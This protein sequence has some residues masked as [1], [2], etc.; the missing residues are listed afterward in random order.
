M[1]ARLNWGIGVEMESHFFLT[2]RV[3]GERQ[4]LAQIVGLFGKDKDNLLVDMKN[5]HKSAQLRKRFGFTKAESDL[6]LSSA[7]ADLEMSA[8]K[9]AGLKPP[10]AKMLELINVDYRNRTVA[11]IAAEMRRNTRRI[12]SVLTKALHDDKTRR[13]MN[14]V[15][16]KTKRIARYPFGAAV[17][18]DLLKQ[19]VVKDYTGSF[20]FTITLPYRADISNSQFIVMH[21]RF[22]NHL[23]WLEPLLVGCLF[24][25]DP[26]CVSEPMY[27]NAAYRTVRYGWGNFAGTDVRRLNKGVGRKANVE[28]LWRRNLNVRNMSNLMT[29]KCMTRQETAPASV[30]DELCGKYGQASSDLRTFGI[31]DRTRVSGPPMTLGNGFEFRIFD[32]FDIGH[33]QDVMTMIMYVAENSR[34]CRYDNEQVYRDLDWISALQDVIHD[35]WHATVRQA[36]VDKV[37]R[38]LELPRVSCV[39]K[40]VHQVTVDVFAALFAKNKGGAWLKLMLGP[41]DARRRFSVPDVNRAAWLHYYKC[42][43]NSA[44]RRA[45]NVALNRIPRGARFRADRAGARLKT[46]H[47]KKQMALVL[48]AEKKEYI[49]KLPGGAYVRLKKLPIPLAKIALTC[50]DKTS[51]CAVK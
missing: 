45:I 28:P 51:N 21:E 7:I 13:A 6:F 36:Y 39:R 34:E 5:P 46:P 22:G 2:D 37:C 8:K 38:I 49:K 32:S 23:Q 12:L 27:V 40:T 33:L 15:D 10:D 11:D 9:C 17:F 35:G 41:A 24:S 20:Q 30:T 47:L 42:A 43:F 25:P 50:N 19:T 29:P 48:D 31:E 3:S 4:K 1:S 18:E 44:N 16:M 26:S 14:I